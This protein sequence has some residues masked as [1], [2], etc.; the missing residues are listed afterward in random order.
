LRR[1]GEVSSL[2]DTNEGRH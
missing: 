1:A 2:T